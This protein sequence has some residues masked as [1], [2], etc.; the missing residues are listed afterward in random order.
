MDDKNK[1][2]GILLNFRTIIDLLT[3]IDSLLNYYSIIETLGALILS[4]LVG[5]TGCKYLGGW[6]GLFTDKLRR[7]R[8]ILL[9]THVLLAIKRY[10]VLVK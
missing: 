10:Y 9:E 5:G 1:Y 7:A 6:Y 8:V 2:F 4:W 3:H